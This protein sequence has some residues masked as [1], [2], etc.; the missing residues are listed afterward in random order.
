MSQRDTILEYVMQ[1]WAEND[2]PAAM[3]WALHGSNAIDRAAIVANICEQQAQTDPEG[4]LSSA[5]HSGLITTSPQT[6][7][8]LFGR[9]AQANPS[10]SLSWALSS[11][12]GARRDALVTQALL[13]QGATDPVGAASLA[14]STLSPGDAQNDVL[15]RLV[16]KWASSQPDQTADWLRS[17]PTSPARDTSIVAF[18]N[19][20]SQTS[21]ASKFR[22]AQSIAGDAIRNNELQSLA[23]PWLRQDVTDARPAILNSNLPDDIKARLLS[24]L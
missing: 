24:N 19:A 6:I 20:T 21:Y 15:T 17:L 7:D 16:T 18:C 10:G 23:G 14:L 9:W 5:V 3:Q 11:T 12:T 1:M 8:Y 13:A 4:A 2:R 22:L